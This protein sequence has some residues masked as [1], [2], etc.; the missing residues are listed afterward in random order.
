M[1]AIIITGK[2]QE[3]DFLLEICFGNTRVGQVWAKCHIIQAGERGIF[4][5]GFDINVF[6]RRQ[7]GGKGM[8]VSFHISVT[9]MRSFILNKVCSTSCSRVFKTWLCISGDSHWHFR[10]C[11]FDILLS[12]A[13]AFRNDW[14][15]P[16]HWLPSYFSAANKPSIAAIDGLALG[17]GLEIALVCCAISLA[18]LRNLLNHIIY[19]P[20]WFSKSGMPCSSINPYCTVRTACSSAWISSCIW[21]FGCFL[22]VKSDHFLNVIHD[23]LTIKQTCICLG[24]SFINYNTYP[25]VEI[26]VSYLISQ[27]KL[28][29]FSISI[30]HC[31]LRQYGYL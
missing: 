11:M 8:F 16:T 7:R 28:T 19:F 12:Y 13:S 3:I 25:N 4:S 21:R 10:R 30:S 2:Y 6:S 9:S 27:L 1:K 23:A 29:F 14:T 17:E 24:N 18:S 5:G 22:R 15:M 20:I 26:R 31:V